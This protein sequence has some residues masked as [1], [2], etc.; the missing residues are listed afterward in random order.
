MH[1]NS[2]PLAMMKNRERQ[3]GNCGRRL[4][5]LWQIVLRR[6]FTLKMVLQLRCVQAT[7]LWTYYLKPTWFRQWI[8]QTW[9]SVL[10]SLESSLKL[11]EA[12]ESI[13]SSVKSFLKG[14]KSV[15]LHAIK[16]I[17]N[18]LVMINH[19]HQQIRQSCLIMSSREKTKSTTYHCTR[20]DVLPN[21][22]TPMSQYLTLCLISKLF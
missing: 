18:F 14:K 5:P 16:S 8:D 19:H 3:P 1:K 12:L 22:V 15:V 20:N 2:W 7:F 21:L 17:L 9:M 6:T 10:A 13:N 4:Q 11:R